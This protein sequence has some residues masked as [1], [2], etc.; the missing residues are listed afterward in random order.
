MN[1]VIEKLTKIDDLA[2][3]IKNLIKEILGINVKILCRWESKG[4]P[5]GGYI[6]INK[7]RNI[8][9]GTKT[10]RDEFFKTPG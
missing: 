9:A 5:L 6:Y 7:M 3:I 1:I 4:D 2:I 10:F 8:R